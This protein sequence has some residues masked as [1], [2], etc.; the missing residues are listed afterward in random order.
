[1]NGKLQFV[2]Q[3]YDNSFS[4]APFSKLPIILPINFTDDL[5][6]QLTDHLTNR[7]V[8]CRDPHKSN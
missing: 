1:M 4:T 3:S 8:R 5:A 6:G 2:A 7:E